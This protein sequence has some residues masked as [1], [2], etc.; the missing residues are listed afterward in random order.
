MAL[1]LAIIGTEFSGPPPSAQDIPDFPVFR[2]GTPRIAAEWEAAFT[3]TSGWTGGDVA[4]SVDLGDGRT[5]W[6]FGDSWFGAAAEGRHLPG[7]IMVNNSIAVSTERNSEIRL[8]FFSGPTDAEGRPTAWIAP[9]PPVVLPDAT[10][11]TWYWPSG[12]V[13]VL[14]GP[15]GARRLAIFLFHVRRI[16]DRSSV[17]N[18]E[19]AGSAV[20][21]VSNMDAPVPNWRV[22]QSA[23]PHAISSRASRESGAPETNW[24]NAVWLDPDGEFLYIYGVREQPPMNKQLILARTVPRAVEQFD[25]WRFYA[26]NDQWSTKSA[27]AAPIAGAMVTEFTVQTWPAGPKPLLI[28]V[29]S[30][31]LFGRRILLRTTRRPE[32]PWSDP[33]PVYTVPDV[34]KDRDYF[35]YAAKGHPHLSPPGALLITYLVNSHDFAKMFN[36][37]S[38]YRPR[39]IRVPLAPAH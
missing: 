33:V 1:V 36:D 3:R 38:I 31:A 35:T 8:E 5:L 11:R 13:A 20:A 39:F 19:S 17:W 2:A 23:I 32:G 29:Q 6:L 22:E 26:G 37:A 28:M 4:A 14:P 16:D 15:D 24:G 30:E 7:S 10:E 9:A 21:I 12:A 18:F 34:E 25:Q 27:D